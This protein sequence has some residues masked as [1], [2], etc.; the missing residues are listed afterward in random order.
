MATI[1]THARAV[2]IGGG[3]SGCSAAYHLARLGWSD[4]VLLERKQLTCGTTWHAAG[5]IGQL[6]ATQNMTRLAKYSADLYVGLEAETGVAT[7]MRQNGSI[8]VA[9]TEDRRQEILR[10]ATMARAFGVEVHEISP[11]EA[12]EM[13]PHL[14]VE[15]V[16]AAV[17][18]PK[19]G[20]AD[21]A[22]IAMATAKGAR[23]NGATVVEGAKVTRV[24][25]DGR[26]VTGVDW[27]MG[28][29]TGHIATDIV[30]NCGG[31]WGRDLAAAS[32]VTLP[33]H[34]CEHFYLVTEPIAGLGQLPVLRVPDECAYYKEDAGKM[35]LGAFEPR[36]KPWGMEGIPEDFCFDSLPEDFEHFEPILEKA[37]S[38]VPLFQSA[39]IHTFFNGPESFTPDD[40]Y[41]LGEA[42]EL[43]GYWV[44]A[45]FNSVG[46]QSAGGTGMALA[47]W[48]EEGE[49][50]FDLWE[51]DI[52]RAQPFQRNRRY[53]RERVTE[54]LGLLYADHW[55]Y[56]QP[57][58]ARGVR[59]SPLHE[60]LK[61]AGAVFGETAGWERANWFANPGQE[62]E[63]RYDW[64]RQNWF[65]NQRAEHMALREGVGLYDMSSF[66][67]IRVEGR[68]ACAFLQR[69]CANDVDVAPG[70]IVYTQMLN[71]R[72]GIESDLT[73]TR[74]SETAFLLVVPAATV[75]RDLSWL[76]RHLH[77]DEFVVITDV[78]ASE[79]VLCV[80]G[81]KSR[82]LMAR[83][84]PDDLTN[85]AHP[86]GLA[87]EIELGMGLARA[88]RVSYVGEL[89]WELYISTEQAAQ[90]FEAIMEAGADMG[91]KLCGLHAMDSCRI[92]KAFR[93]FG[94]DISDEDHVLE[95]G[96]GFA[97]KPDK[98]EFIG[99]EAVLRKREEG[100]KRRMVQF[101]LTD[102]EPMLF[103]NE[104]LV[105]DGEIV[106]YITSANYGHFL[107]GAIGMGYVPC[108]GESAEE[109]L[110]SSYEIEIA[111][112]RVPAV[113]SLRPMYDP[114]AE[115]VRM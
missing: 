57:V 27:Q 53:L 99:R 44:A 92:E 115:R 41:Y 103:H 25:D 14:N 58:T 80:M 51:V 75:I 66:G 89:G 77:E 86:F 73:V 13:Y 34:A 54:T 16:V 1:P 113:A 18:L 8:T 7:G 93:H 79:A 35:M 6:R 37:M 78:T 76:R 49:P 38:R 60:H 71:W 9:L 47:H 24:T 67:K 55:P 20:Q 84:S 111:G 101:R 110:A 28:E 43:R 11:S 40:R 112:T 109:V 19:D 90:A 3:V 88:H 72:G 29:E 10:Q 45:G 30:I 17:H 68:D 46:I 87:R 50:P 32:G 70:R 31:M 83:V 94:H 91:L 48:L 21:P 42:P 105:R 95:A 97:V 98:G 100:L 22:N 96:L 2:I 36:A 5:L 85:E 4:I 62:R 23:M 81:P 39:G 108:E 69:L 33:L 63:Y 59:R 26:R 15:D 61:A 74:L 102:P 104:A 106:S 52:R 64:G 114:K 65:D 12:K 82:E 107:G 56:R